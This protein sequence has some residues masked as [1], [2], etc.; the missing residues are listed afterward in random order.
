[1]GQV[2]NKNG[3]SAAA[4]VFN[5]RAKEYDQWFEDSLL[6]V[7]ELSCLRDLKTKIERP[8]LE[9]GVGPGRFARELLIDYGLDPAP[10]PLVLARRRGIKVVQAVGESLPFRSGS[11]AAVYILFTFCFLSEPLKVLQESFRILKPS[12]QVIVGIISSSSAWGR[13]LMVKKENNH[14]F[15]RY[16]RFYEGDY[17][18]D[19]L[20]LHS[21]H[22]V[23][24][25]SILFQPPERL[26][27]LERSRPG[28][29]PEAGF[30]VIVGEKKS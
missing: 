14:P 7:V 17:L 8:G 30:Q 9:I 28:I 29:W 12:G 20:Y 21:F 16:A 4:E 26:D 24:S 19:L 6:F 18:R 10:A 1:M 15:Y 13:S 22:P 3:A 23:D 11:L 5:S 25:R 27:R 2:D